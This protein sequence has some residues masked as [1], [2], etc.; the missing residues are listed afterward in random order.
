M[1]SAAVYRGFDAAT[2][3][4]PA[5]LRAEIPHHLIDVADPRRD[6]SAGDYA[7]LAGAA[8]DRI[9]AAG[10]RAVLVGGTGLYLRVL[11]RGLAE[12]P[13]RNAALRD[14]LVRWEVRRGEGSLHR[15]LASLDPSTAQR[16]A[17]RDRQ[18]IV[19]AVEVIFVTGRPMSSLIAAS[20]FGEEMYPSAKIGLMM[21]WR[22]LTARIEARVEEFFA[23]GLVEEVR[24]LLGA[25]V[26]RGAN[27]FKALGYREVLAHLDG[28][29]SLEETLALVKLSTR[30]YAR[31]QLTWFRREPGVV[32]FELGDRP[33]E[34]FA[35]IEAD[36]KL[37]LTVKES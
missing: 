8:I 6:F 22:L 34:R 14:A 30:R 3:K 37:R 26:P 33:E 11:M 35:E 15:M 20:P 1:D 13:R 18:R 31:R 16:L 29:L 24:G 36:A 28:K 2:A 27:A 17:P 32:W 23:A 12:M 9:H 4:P 5:S 21:S 10:R 19:R 25:G 7:R